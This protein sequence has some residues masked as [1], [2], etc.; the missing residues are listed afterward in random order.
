[1]GTKTIFSRP[2]NTFRLQEEEQLG[3][4]KFNVKRELV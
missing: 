1:M 2:G 4:S 3:F